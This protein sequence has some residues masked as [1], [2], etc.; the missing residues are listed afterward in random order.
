MDQ[1]QT[2]F[3]TPAL[4]ALASALPKVTDTDVRRRIIDNILAAL[5][6]ARRQERAACAHVC[7]TAGREDIAE[8]IRARGDR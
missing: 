8:T 7:V 4:N 6:E 2:S 3:K 5:N 1:D